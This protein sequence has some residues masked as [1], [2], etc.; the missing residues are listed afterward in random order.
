[1]MLSM[2]LLLQS[3]TLGTPIRVCH[4]TSLKLFGLRASDKCGLGLGFG[5]PCFRPA[6]TIIYRPHNYNLGFLTL[7]VPPV[8]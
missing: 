2:P 8:Y 7:L 6:A 1:M 4:A 3:C 5:L